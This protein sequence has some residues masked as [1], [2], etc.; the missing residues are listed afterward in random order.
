MR[1]SNQENTPM[2][3]AAIRAPP[4]PFT[5]RP[6]TKLPLISSTIAP[7]TRLMMPPRRPFP[8]WIPSVLSSQ[9]MSPVTTAQ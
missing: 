2:A 9:L 5:F 7:T 4:K 3:M 6:G 1:L 8:M